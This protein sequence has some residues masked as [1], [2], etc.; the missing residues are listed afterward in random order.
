VET[1]REQ[2]G[3]SGLSEGDSLFEVLLPG[4]VSLVTA[5]SSSSLSSSESELWD[6]IMS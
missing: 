3:G 1:K 2:C 5:C 4:F 6:R